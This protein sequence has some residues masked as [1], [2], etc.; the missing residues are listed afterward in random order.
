MTLRGKNAP[1]GANVAPAGRAE[2]E[3]TAQQEVG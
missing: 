2:L 1:A 3:R